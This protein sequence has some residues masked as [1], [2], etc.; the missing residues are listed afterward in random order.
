MKRLSVPSAV[1]AAL[2][3][4][5]LVPAQTVTQEPIVV[6]A[7]RTART[8]DETLASV[9]V[10]TRE[11]IERTQAKSVAE[12]L[13]GE[14]GID[15]AINGGYGKTT[16]LYLRGTNAD[17]VLTLIDGVKIGSATSGSASW[18]Y[19]PVEQIERI[20]IVRGPRSSLYGSEAIGGVIQIF[21][22]Q[23]TDKFQGRAEAGYGSYGTRDLSAG[24][25]GANES[26]RYSLSAGNFNTGGIDAKTA[27]AGNEGDTDGF[28]NE[29]L[30]ARLSH[31]FA[32][33]AEIEAHALHA[34]GHV[35]YDGNPNQAAFTQDATGLRLNFSPL[36]AW[37][38]KLQAG[39]SRDYSDN[40]KDGRFSSTFNTLRN[41]ASWQN[42]VT[43]GKNQLLTAGVDY[44]DDRIGSTTGYARTERNNT[45]VFLQ[46]QGR[47]GNHDVIAGLRQDNNEQFGAYDT[48]NLA[49]GYALSPALRA[50][51][52]YGTAFKAPTFNQ[53]YYP[54]GYGNPNLQ[55]EEST[56]YEAGLHGRESWGGWDV[57]A[58]Q[59]NV[60]NLIA[61]VSSTYTNVN[62]ARIKGVETEL[63]AVLGGWNTRLSLSL[64]DPRDT[65]ADKILARRTKRSLKFEADR[66]FGRLR[67]GA[68]WLVQGHRY[69]DTANTARLGGFAVVN[70]RA[71][72]DLAKG[73]FVRT[74]LE[75]VFDKT[76]HTAAQLPPLPFGHYN[77]PGR[78]LFVSL[79]YRTN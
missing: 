23:P 77:S 68:D 62:Q 58:Y 51:L 10:I 48:G 17:H 21:T 19:L 46:H 53:L 61:T 73:W 13:T 1:M 44:Q 39:N 2:L 25:S 27:S 64:M 18:Q 28:R 42:D 24:V 12:L 37:A 52:S 20:E 75:N 7:T 41:V 40:F 3:F 79:G 43:L 8:A 67:F 69:D 71:Q 15:T 16:S 78:S 45:G 57:R 32:S 76:Y 49:W 36:D 31:R 14:A 22:R 33:G 60:N 11:D 29:S 38:V 63:T 70:L 55:P 26:T 54:N 72:Y 34:Q 50:R 35:E 56:S 30:S 65:I 66:A 74:R 9:T 6:T 47:F 59:T 4:P 5:S